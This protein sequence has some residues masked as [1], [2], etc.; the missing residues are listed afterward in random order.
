MFYRVKLKDYVDLSPELFEGDL[1]SSIKE[2]LNR[3]NE[4]LPFHLQHQ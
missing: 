1:N 4:R 2:Q 3:N